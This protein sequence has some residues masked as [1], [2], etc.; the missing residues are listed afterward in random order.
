MNHRRLVSALMLM[1][2]C[3]GCALSGHAAAVWGNLVVFALSVGIFLS[4]LALGR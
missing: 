4:T 3:S 2:A 1:F